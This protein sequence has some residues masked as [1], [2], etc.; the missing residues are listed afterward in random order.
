[1]PLSAALKQA[2]VT[3]AI[4]PTDWQIP[5]PNA[6]KT[7]LNILNAFR[8]YC[9]QSKLSILS[10]NGSQRGDKTFTTLN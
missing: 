2:T 8:L 1:M 10:I 5:W 6:V 4:Q 7:C 9:I 3:A